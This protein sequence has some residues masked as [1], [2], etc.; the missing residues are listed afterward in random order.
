[1]LKADRIRTE[2]D[3]S[4]YMNEVGE[5]G[6]IVV[7]ADVGTGVAMDDVDQTVEIT[8]TVANARVGGVLM[9]DVV[10]KDLTKT[11]INFHNGEVQVGGKVTVVRKGQVTTDQVSGSEITA[12]GPAYLAAGGTLSSTQ[13]S[14]APKVG[15]FLTAQDADGFVRVSLSL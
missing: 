12:P 11:H 2:E 4:F 13:A 6:Q 15:D 3:L 7:I 8:D 9:Q 14:D 1:M 10:N 5:A